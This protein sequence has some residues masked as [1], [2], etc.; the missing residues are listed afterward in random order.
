MRLISAGS[1]VQISASL[2]RYHNAPYLRGLC[3]FW[4]SKQEFWHKFLAQNGY[5]MDYILQRP[6]GYYFRLMVP[7]DLKALIG[8]S[9]IR[10]TLKTGSLSLAKERACLLSGRLKKLFRKL[11]CR[12][13]Y[14]TSLNSTQYIIKNIL[15]EGH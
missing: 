11:R 7:S 6:S 8:I 15:T 4:G 9:E 5:L 12:N 13:I 2:P 1:G 14:R 3:C 10:R